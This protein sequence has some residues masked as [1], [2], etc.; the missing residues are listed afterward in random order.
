M[1][2]IEIREGLGKLSKDQ[3]TVLY[4]TLLGKSPDWIA[5]EILKK[6]R[7]TFDYHMGGI[8]SA[9]GFFE[10]EHWTIKRERLI[11]EV[12]PIFSELV[13]DEKDLEK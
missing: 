4:W 3:A 11:R 2:E 7:K 8:Y 6:E 12:Y 13:K 1:S 5:R 10:K 9:L